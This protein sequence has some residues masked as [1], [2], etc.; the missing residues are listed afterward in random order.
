MLPASELKEYITWAASAGGSF[1]LAV[2]ENLARYPVSVSEFIAS[3]S[4]LGLNN[5]YGAVIESLEEIYHPSVEGLSVPLRIG[6]HYREVLLTGSLGCA[7][8][9]TSVL[10]ILYGI[11]LLS[12]LRRPHDLFGLDSN[13]EIVFLLQSIRFQTGGVAYKLARGIIE[14]SHFFS[15]AF[16]KDNRVKNEILLPNNIVI[17]P[18]SGELT[19]AIGMNVATVLLDEMSYMRYHAKS[20]NAEDGGEYDQARALY[21]TTRARIDSRFSKLGRYLIPMFL[22]GSARHEED[23]IQSKIREQANLI[24]LGEEPGVYVYNK[25]IWDI[26]PWDYPSG[27]FFRVFLGLGAV[28]PQVVDDHSEY[29]QSEH[30]IDVPME[31][32]VA[33]KAQPINAALRD[34]CGI[35][36]KEVGT[37]VVEVERTKSYFNRR[38]IFSAESCTFLGGDLPQV[39]RDFVDNPIADRPWFCHLDLSRTSDSTG[40]AMGYVDKWI[41]NRPQIVVAGLLEVPPIPGYVIPWDAIMYFIF[42][43]SEIVPLYAVSA[44]QVGYH[45]LAEQL[46]PYGYKI[47]RISDNPRSE[48]YHNFLNALMEGDISI[49]QHPKTLDEFLALN[50][51]EKTGKV[52]KPA[53]GS[54]DCADA[55][56]S[57]VALMKLVPACKHELSSWIK[58]T[59]P[60]LTRSKNGQY[61]AVETND[62]QLGSKITFMR[63]S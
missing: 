18:V 60:E 3:D 43:F 41:N 12:C 11:Y 30:V 47:A 14:G 4:Y 44:D 32:E 50:V 51:D 35:P 54:K 62:R 42:R 5:V 56:V 49:A 61:S 25:R 55:L 52:E 6:T 34:I 53:G 45:Y 40:I 36:S 10:G 21:S 1:D 26:K 38:N 37:F 15:K 13:S 27:D 7:K 63:C 17:R 29:Y 31:L 20:V 8:T 22:A 24:S 23:F 2:M 28:P 16:P 9:Y 48:M 33:F 39:Q 58:P 59:P 46:V 57:L 19:A